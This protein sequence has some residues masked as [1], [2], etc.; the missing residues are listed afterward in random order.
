MGQEGPGEGLSKRGIVRICY[1]ILLG[2]EKKRTSR[3]KVILVNVY[4]SFFLS[5][6]LFP[7]LSLYLYQ[8]HDPIGVNNIN[9]REKTKESYSRSLT[10]DFFHNGGAN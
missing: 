10:V 1:G 7:F 2:K 8:L 9:G 5:P 3:S 4:F 6:F